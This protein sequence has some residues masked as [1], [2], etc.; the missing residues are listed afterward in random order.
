ML[1]ISNKLTVL[2]EKIKSPLSSDGIRLMVSETM[3]K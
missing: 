1:T 3:I 2:L